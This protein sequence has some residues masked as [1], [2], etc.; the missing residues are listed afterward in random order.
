MK[1]NTTRILLIEDHPGDA[2]LVREALADAGPGVFDLVWAKDLAR[3][4]ARLK[5]D[6][7]D[8]LLLDLNLQDSAGL[9]T[10]EKVHTAAPHLPV[11]LLTGLNDEEQASR[12]VREGAQD[13]LVKGQAD[14][15]LLTRSIRYAIDRKKSEQALRESE[16]RYRMLA[17]TAQDMIFIINRKGMVEYVNEYAAQAIGHHSSKVI[18]ERS[19]GFFSP[20]VSTRQWENI[21][22]VFESGK[23]LYYEGE[24]EFPGRKLWLGSWLVPMR[25]E[26]GEVVSVFGIS[27]DITERKQSEEAQKRRLEQLSALN[28]VSQAVAVS[29]DLNQVLT[30]V[31]SQAGKVSA[32]D[33]VSVVLVDEDGRST[34]GLQELA[35]VKTINYQVREKGFTRWIAR[36]RRPVVV[37]EIGSGG[38]VRPPVGERAPRTA[39]PLLVE[40]GVRSFV[41]L[42][43]M[44]Q[45][46]VLGVLYL[47][48]LR[49]GAFRDQLPLLTTFANQAAIAIEKARLYD[50]IQKELAERKQT[51]QALQESESRYHSLFDASPLG[52]GIS[53]LDGNPLTLNAAM[54]KITGYSLEELSA[55]GIGNTYVYPEERQDLFRALR[56]AGGV[57]D[58]EVQLMRKDGSIYTALL[59]V[60]RIELGGQQVVY[61]ILRDITERKQAEEQI[62]KRNLE[63]AALNRIGQAFS[64]LAA[65]DEIVEQLY[66]NI[67]Q[68]LD[69]RNLYIALYDE[70]SQTV[71]FPVYALH[72]ERRPPFQRP[73]GNGLTE[74]VLRTRAPLL[75]ARDEGAFLAGQGIALIGTPSKSFLAAPIR[76]GER[77]LGVIA[78]QDYERENVYGTSDL[79]LLDTLAAQA[80]IALENSRLYGAIQQELIERK[81]AEQALRD[82]EERY[83]LLF[84]LSPD[85]VAVYQD[86]KIVFVNHAAARLIGADSPEALVGRP[87][88]DFVHPDYRALVA[89][90]SRQQIVEG[91]SVPGAEEKF[92]R[93]D[94][95]VIDVEVTAAPFLYMD[96]PASMVIIHDITKRTQA[97]GALRDSE[98]RFREIFENISSGVVVYEPVEAGED[99]IIKN[100]NRAAERIEKIPRADALGKKVCEVFPGVKAFGLFDVFQRVL[101]TGS[102][103]HYPAGLY[104]DG[105][106]AGWRENYIAR[107]PSGEIVA[108]YDDV[109]DRKQAEQALHESEARFRGAVEAAGAVPYSYSYESKNYTFIGKGILALTGYTDAEITPALFKSLIR[110]RYMVGEGNQLSPED[111]T[112]HMVAGMLKNWRCDNLILTRNGK[113]CWVADA[114][115]AVLD[116]KGTVIGSIGFL[117]DISERKQVEEALARQT[118][119]LAHRNKELNRLYRA[120]ASLISSSP[121]DIQTLGQTIVNVILEEFGQSN[122][123]LFLIS[124][125]LNE[126]KR[127]AV[128]GPYSEEVSRKVLTLDG[129]GLVP[130]AIRTGQVINTPDVQA[131]PAYL[132]AWEAAHSELTIPLKIGSQTIGAIDVQ[133]AQADFF[134]A[135]DERLMTIFAERAALALEHTRLFTKT[136]RRM[137][138]LVSLRTIDSAISSSFNLEITLDIL[139]DQVTK[140]L[141]VDAADVLVFNPITQTFQFSA[142]QGFRTQALQY[143]N[144]RL[145]D[146]Y[147]GRAARERRKVVVE[148]LAG[149]LAGFQRSVYFP[150]EGFASYI[151]IPLMAKGQIKGVLEIFHRSTLE[152]DREENDFL[153]MLAGQAAIAIDN[154]ELFEKL[155]GSN[156]ELMMAYDETIEGWSRAMDLRDEE[157]EGH[158]QRV[159]QITLKLASDIGFGTEEMVHVRR[160][161]LLHDIGKMGVP[162]SILRKP[163]PLT[164]E[165]WVIMRKHPQFAYNM[166]APVAYLR[167]ALDIP[168][169]HHEKWDGSGYP[170]SLKGEQIPLAAR[171]FSVVDV[172]DALM[173]NRPYR[174]AWPEDRVREYIREQ[175]GKHFDPKIVDIFLREVLNV[176]GR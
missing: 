157:T 7:I 135:D 132:P 136:E 80:A 72:G 51:E 122:C 9:A 174:N 154:S 20:D 1:K 65:P 47:H 89:E 103:E 172:W 129:A 149:H 117:Q 54:E 71:S 110:E 171:I 64:R 111:A 77:I 159:T 169:C 30:E 123:S 121:F 118:E 96:K 82:S 119:E 66:V 84:E 141:D 63:L 50:A 18:G 40:R 62:R 10:F 173:S 37:D 38:V 78:V 86:G 130:Q 107:L 35:G 76:A 42:P 156:A 56:E 176:E 152:L 140:Q 53:D 83:R 165:E 137:Q 100:F 128:A 8:A 109:T 67:G 27:R 134:S 46:R 113:T 43:L 58:W 45:D 160:G 13:Y 161:A 163:G 52:I 94:G 16:M 166:L 90:R 97:E 85:A 91:K 23:P 41:G 60:D 93:M 125:E 2:R 142:G 120:S 88:M 21:K 143:T 144:I 81:Q 32:S 55:K 4:L 22:K 33:S 126:L 112:K 148:D 19:R 98:E 167:P 11:I 102:P 87:M 75:I 139:L 168:Y 44:I 34:G 48:S 61:T 69:N 133:S 146:G 73:F 127:V 12:A 70:A 101:K 95:S 29:L 108:V 145:G 28:Q 153:D 31:V 24:T 162:D 68:M 155:Q 25:S 39:N 57:R 5:K 3:G 104:Q 99:F 151:G 116:K 79:E 17:E 92:I 138:N 15:N 105:R 36:M 14:G 150:H 49:S 114:S 147:A 164:D 106:V 6:A 175:A 59:N 26:G 115:V 170:R 158:T 131:I 124:E 74:Y